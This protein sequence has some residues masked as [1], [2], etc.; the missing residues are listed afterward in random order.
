MQAKADQLFAEFVNEMTAKGYTLISAE[1]AG[2]TDTY[3][4]WKS[5]KGP[6]I[7]ETDMTGILTVVPSGYS[8]FLQRP[9]RI[10]SYFGRF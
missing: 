6:A 4:G 10:F 9:E 3:E 5:M 8:F 1:E 7:N 2:K